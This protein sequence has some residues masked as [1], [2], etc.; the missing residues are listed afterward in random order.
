MSVPIHPA[1]TCIGCPSINLFDECAAHASSSGSFNREQ[2]LQIADRP[3]RD[4]AAMKQE[5]RET[6]HLIPLLC[7]QGVHR[8]VSVEEARPRHACNGIWQRG[9]LFAA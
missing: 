8:I 7:D 1:A 2:V 5:M 6:K 3:Q 9:L 4:G